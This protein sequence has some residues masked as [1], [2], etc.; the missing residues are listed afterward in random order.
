[1]RTKGVNNM[2]KESLKKVQDK[3]FWI[4]DSTDI[5]IL[6][7][8]ELVINLMH[9]LDEEKY[10]ENIKILSKNNTIDKKK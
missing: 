3:I 6:D 9:F 10:E 8:I 4:I 1:M 2:N 7:K 5:D